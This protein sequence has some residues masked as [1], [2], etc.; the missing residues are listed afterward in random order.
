MLSGS[1][2]RWHDRQLALHVRATVVATAVTASP[3]P[4]RSLRSAAEPGARPAGR[5]R[6]PVRPFQ[7]GVAPPPSAA[8]C[9]L[10][11]APRRPRHADTTAR[12]A[13]RRNERWSRHPA[14]RGASGECAALRAPVRPFQAEGSRSRAAAATARFAR[15]RGYPARC[16]APTP[17]RA[18]GSDTISGG[19]GS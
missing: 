2:R 19:A 17:P 18:L 15:Y 7:A 5:V 14:Q 8:L 3:P 6:A 1:P 9:A 12:F 16:T 13:L 11:C 4:P 10:P